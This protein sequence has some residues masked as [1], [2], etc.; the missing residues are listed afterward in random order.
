MPVGKSQTHSRP[1]KKYRPSTGGEWPKSA[2][3]VII[4]SWKKLEKKS[5]VLT[6]TTCSQKAERG[7][8]RLGARPLNGRERGP[9]HEE[10]T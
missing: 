1:W 5:L 2:E 7:D 9:G 3:G 10:S 8:K 6:V 4:S